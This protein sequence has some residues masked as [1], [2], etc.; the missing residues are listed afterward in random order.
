RGRRGRPE[1]PCADAH[2]NAGGTHAARLADA[3][4]SASKGR[5]K[6]TVARRPA[7]T[8]IFH[9]KRPRRVV[10]DPRLGIC[11]SLAG[12]SGGLVSLGCRRICR[13]SGAACPPPPT[14]EP[15]PSGS[16]GRTLPAAAASRTQ[17]CQAHTGHR[18]VWRTPFTRMWPTGVAIIRLDAG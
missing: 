3:A 15:P 2:D 11:E 18:P 17:D 1:Q 9:A 12:A 4:L 16:H 13:A 10:Q 6:E 7:N 14:T 8:R 5:V